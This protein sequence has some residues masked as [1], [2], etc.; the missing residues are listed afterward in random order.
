MKHIYNLAS[1]VRALLAL[2][3]VL[4]TTTAKAEDD[5]FIYYDGKEYP[6]LSTRFTDEGNGNFKAFFYFSE[7]KKSYASV[8][9]NVNLHVRNTDNPL[10]TQLNTD[11]PDI[12]HTDASVF[13]WTVYLFQDGEMKLCADGDPNNTFPTFNSETMM[14]INGDPRTGQCA[15]S[16]PQVIYQSSQYS[17]GQNHKFSMLWRKEYNAPTVS[18]PIIRAKT[19][20]TKT[21]VSWKRATDDDTPAEKLY[22]TIGWKLPSANT[23]I[24]HVGYDMT[25]YTITGLTPNTTYDCDIWVTDYSG[26]TYT[27][28]STQ[29]TTRATEEYIKISEIPVTSS[30]YLD[31]SAAGGFSSIK[32]GT[33]TY[34]PD[35]KTLTLNNVN[36]DDNSGAPLENSNIDGLNIA[37]KG[38][39]AI[40]S[41]GYVG[42]Y[43]PTT[44]DGSGTGKLTITSTAN[45]A[46]H[47][48]STLLDIKNCE[49]T[50]AGQHGGIQGLRGD[51]EKVSV[52]DAKLTAISNDGASPC[53][54]DINSLTLSGCNLVSPAGAVFNTTK[55]AVCDA[56][57][58]YITTEVVIGSEK[59][60]GLFIGDK[61]I[62]SE[63]YSNITSANGFT[64]IENGTVKFDPATM[65]LKL[66]KAE[67]NRKTKY[68][69]ENIG[70]PLTISLT[71]Q[72]GVAGIKSEKDLVIE[73]TSPA[74]SQIVCFGN[75]GIGIYMKNAD[76]T[77]RTCAGNISGSWGIAGYQGDTEDVK[78]MNAA[79]KI[80]SDNGAL[81]DINSLSLTECHIEEPAGAAF[82]TATKS[83]CYPNGTIVKEMTIKLGTTAIDGVET[84]AAATPTA[85]F[86]AGGQRRATM[87]KGMNIV[88]M[89]DGTTRK[90]MVR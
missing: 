81:S 53:I 32:S 2:L 19:C 23:W 82:N 28:P 22:Y 71:G 87:Q 8:W 27:Y 43:K 75:D 79:L 36:I 45:H 51:S 58:N 42:I 30:N 3:L 72:C 35:S 57:G 69:I 85:L 9:G 77:I 34:D 84:D 60:Y 88:R 83:V 41:S 68:A 48:E 13:Y 55:H 90:V 20:D 67:I 7:D 62:T 26:N 5:N 49:M 6:I 65:T 64:T 37:L 80:Q 76:L 86:S 24:A 11:E 17:D 21:K 74:K 33:V 46:L 40:T 50:L 44:F 70:N 61:E 66:N 78:I 29:F 54:F 47:T 14:T 52:T 25:D 89:S 63:N 38:T 1:G 73:G 15:I 18:T 59:G 31:I 16:I 4:C 56:S 12:L 10:S 39:N